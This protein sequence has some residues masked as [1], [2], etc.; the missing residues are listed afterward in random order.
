MKRMPLTVDDRRVLLEA[1]AEAHV[2]RDAAVARILAL[3]RCTSIA[4]LFAVAWLAGTGAELGL[5]N[6]GGPPSMW[7]GYFSWAFSSHRGPVLLVSVAVAFACSFL[8][9]RDVHARALASAVIGEVGEVLEEAGRGAVGAVTAAPVV[10]AVVKRLAATRAAARRAGEQ[11]SA[12]A[13]ACGCALLVV[14][15]GR[16]VAGEPGVGFTFASCAVVPFAWLSHRRRARS[17]SRRVGAPPVADD[18]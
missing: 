1:S 13:L 5:A 15:L 11:R 10:A 9:A 4:S 3:Q 17:S 6:R 16:F 2:L 12:A 8:R 14:A 18:D 7:L